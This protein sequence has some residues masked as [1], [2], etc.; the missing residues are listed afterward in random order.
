[1]RRNRLMVKNIIIIDDEKGLVEMLKTA[2]G[3]KGFDASGYYS[4]KEGLAALDTE[5]FDLC[6][7][8]VKMPEM[9]GIQFLNELKTRGIK[10]NV[11]M[12][13]AYSTIETAIEAI[14]AG[15]FDFISKPFK[16]DELLMKIQRLEE[17]EQLKREKEELTVAARKNFGFENIIAKSDS[18][19][20]LFNMVRKVADY[21]TTVLITGESGTGKELIARSIHFNSNRSSAPFVAIN[22][23]AIPETLLES[24]LFGHVKGSFTDAW[25]NKKG[26]FETAHHGTIL[27]DEI[28]ELSMG[29][30]VKLQRVLQEGEIRKV[31][32]TVSKK[33]DVRVIAATVKDLSEEV[34]HGNFRDDLYY[35]LNVLTIK[36][37]PLR[38][39]PEDIHLLVEHFVSETI[40]RLGIR[41]KPKISSETLKLLLEYRWPGNVR[42]L[43]NVIERAIVLAEGNVIKPE[44]LPEKLRSPAEKVRTV[45]DSESLSIKKAARTMEEGLIRRALEYTKGNRTAASELLEISTRALIYKIQEYGIKDKD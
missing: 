26:L 44:T 41:E 14:K 21:K 42:D 3:K 30:Q 28:G 38:E 34:S 35:R 18:M 27:L 10:I 29:L 40:S 2:L 7:C 39:R 45:I 4:A 19:M 17:N 37:P 9:D 20:G 12:M 6:L 31:G 15:A 22:C 13:S 32:E 8:D 33:V 23:G 36:I 1:M 11:I 5:N 43:E 16:I 25:Q 24:E